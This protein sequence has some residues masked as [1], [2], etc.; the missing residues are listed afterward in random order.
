MG[1]IK[2]RGGAMGIA[3]ALLLAL[4]LH[5]PTVAAEE[6]TFAYEATVISVSGGLGASIAVDDV[7]TGQITFDP[8]ATDESTTLSSL[9]TYAATGFTAGMGPIGFTSTSG[10]KIVVTNSAF[11][12]DTYVVRGGVV[13]GTT[14][15]IYSPTGMNLS[16]SDSTRTAFSSDALPATP[17]ALASF[18]IRL[19]TIEFGAGRTITAQVTSLTLVEEETAIEVTVDLKPGSDDNPVNLTSRGKTPVAILTTSDFDAA[20]VDVDTVMLG[21]P[22]LVAVAPVKSSLTDVDGDGDLDLLLHFETSDLAATALD[23]DSTT[24][25]L[26][27]KTT[28]GLAIS[29]SDSVKIVK[30]KR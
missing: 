18:D 8:A 11:F 9:G 4:G 19:L 10:T 12:P 28:G 13:T 5:S 27:G 26:T 16:L 17:P 21:D 2:R 15:G 14:L 22:D 23:P 3:L 30:G 7:L 25:T 6:V 29:G 20:D 24:V 1:R